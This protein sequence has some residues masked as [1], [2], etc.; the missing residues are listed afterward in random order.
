[1]PAA[2]TRWPRGEGRRVHRIAL[3]LLPSVILV[4]LASSPFIGGAIPALTQVRMFASQWNFLSPASLPIFATELAGI[5]PGPISALALGVSSYALLLC[6]LTL[7]VRRSC[8]AA[9]FRRTVAFEV[10]DWG[11]LLFLVTLSLP[12]FSHWYIPWALP[13][14][15]NSGG[16]IWGTVLLLCATTPLLDVVARADAS[17]A[18]HYGLRLAM[19]IGLVPWLLGVSTVE[20]GK[21][22]RAPCTDA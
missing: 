15:W 12:S 7:V 6:S 11:V 8:R 14:L 4:L 2:A 10:R 19:L 5:D 17:P 9:R 22:L 13:L 3:L 1:L 16:L 21:R 18:L 20:L